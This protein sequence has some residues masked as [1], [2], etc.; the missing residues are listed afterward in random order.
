MTSVNG[1]APAVTTDS[2]AQEW[3][4]IIA[5]T[6][7]FDS[8]TTLVRHIVFRRVN[9]VIGSD[10]TYRPIFQ[11][12]YRLD[13]ERIEIG[14][15]TPCPD[16]CAPNDVGTYS[17]DDGAITLTTHWYGQAP[18]VTFARVEALQ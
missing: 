13:G 14:S 2:T 6:L 8:D 17:P 12:H 11:L 16:L 9:T 10:D 3:G 18:R 15:F 5:D 4:Q 7:V 1:H